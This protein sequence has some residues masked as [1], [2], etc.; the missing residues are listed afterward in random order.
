M[1]PTFTILPKSRHQNNFILDSEI[2]WK[3]VCVLTP[4]QK[5]AN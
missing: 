1:K 2:F 3:E 5:A 4:A